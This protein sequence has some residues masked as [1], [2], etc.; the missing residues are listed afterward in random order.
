[1]LNKS[2]GVFVVNTK[3]MVGPNLTRTIF[4]QQEDLKQWNILADLPE[5]G[6][7]WRKLASDGK[8]RKINLMLNFTAEKLNNV[9][10][11]YRL[12]HER[13]D[14]RQEEWTQRDEQ[15]R[16]ALHD[17]LLLEELGPPPYQYSWGEVIST[18]DITGTGSEIKISYR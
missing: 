14:A 16:K 6:Y 12:P 4:K 15:A 10:L 8:L 11:W 13:D 1:M 17:Q 2:S 18:Y 3:L 9:S 7:Y 5:M